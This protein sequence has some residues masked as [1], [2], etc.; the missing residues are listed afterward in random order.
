MENNLS[1]EDI[2]RGYRAC[3]NTECGQRNECMH[4]QA[5]LLMPDS[6]L[7]GQAVYPAAWKN[8]PCQC[9]CHKQRVRKA[10]GF[11]QLYK[12]VSRRYVPDARKEVHAYLGSGQSTYYRVH[13]GERKLTP[14][15]QK[16]ILNILA[17]YGS[18]A[19]V[20]FDHYV[21]EYDFS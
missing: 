2:P 15:Q 13:H 1:I 12:N 18:I 7:G 3:F 8:G 10:W 14:K 17:K 19:D 6:K 5:G 4:Y 11:S 21:E 20:D 9:F 16:D